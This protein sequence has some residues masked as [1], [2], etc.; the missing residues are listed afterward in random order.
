MLALADEFRDSSLATQTASV[1]GRRADVTW[2]DVTV[3]AACSQI[4]RGYEVDVLVAEEILSRQDLLNLEDKA[5][6]LD[7]LLSSLA[8]QL[9]CPA[10]FERGLVVIGGY[11]ARDQATVSPGHVRRGPDQRASSLR[12]SGE[13][14]DWGGLA[15]RV[16]AAAGL[17][18]E[19]GP[20]SLRVSLGPVWADGDAPAILS[21]LGSWQDPGV[22]F[23]TDSGQIRMVVEAGSRRR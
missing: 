3:A 18:V 4:R 15:D 21:A 6:T 8:L 14:L 11:R 16:E 13:S 10:Y 9:G 22:Q 17:P 7:R 23:R 2:Q 19:L 20:D 5:I 12:L 1:L